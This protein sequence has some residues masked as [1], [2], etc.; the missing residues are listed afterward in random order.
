[1][2]FPV[3]ETCLRRQVSK[4]IFSQSEATQE[5]GKEMEEQNP[6]GPGTGKTTR[7]STHPTHGQSGVE[8]GEGPVPD[9][10]D[11]LVAISD[12]HCQRF[13]QFRYHEASG[14]REVCSQL[15]GLCNQW[16]KP[17]KN[18]KKQIL[19]LVILEQFLTILPQEMQRWARG[20]GPETSSQAVALAEGFLLSQTEKRQAEQMWAPSM[21]EEATFPEAEGASLEEGQRVQ[22]QEGAQ[23]ALPCENGEMLLGH[24]LSR[25]VET[26]AAAPVQC[27]FSL[28]EVSVSFTEAEWALLDPGQRAL[29]REVMLENYGNVAFLAEN[30]Q[31][32]EEG[33]EFHPQLPDRVKNEGLEKKVKNRDR[34]KRNKEGRM[35]EK[36]DGRKYNVRFPKHR[37]MKPSKSIQ[38]RKHIWN[39]S[40][41][42]VHQ[43]TNTEEKPFECSECGKKFSES[44]GLQKHQRTHTGEKPFECAVCGKK[45]SQSG[46]LQKHRRTH[47]AEKPFEC[48]VCGK[49]FSQSGNLQLHQRT[50]TG[51]KPFECSECG[52]RFSQS[53]TL[54]LHQRIHTGEK[55]FECSECGKKFSQSGHLQQHQRIH[56]AEKPFECSECGKRFSNSGTLLR[57]Q[58]SHTGEKPF[59]CLE[60]GKKFNQSNDLLQH[61]TTHAGEKPFECSECGKKFSHRR[62]LQQHL[63]IHRGDKPFECSECGKRF[64]R[65]ANLQLHQRTHTG[66]KPFECTLCG[67]KF[68]QSCHLKLHQG[69]HTGEKPFECSECGKG[70]RLSGHLQKHLTSHTGEKPYECSQCGKRFSQSG[71]LQKHQRTHAGENLLNAQVWKEVQVEWQFSTASNKPHRGEA[72]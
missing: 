55:P 2:P 15:H 41:L 65:S 30:D 27:P 43:K 29:Y 68:S 50:H 62:S 39:K 5:N 49:K 23:D 60:C 11:E 28:D 32:N 61:Q 67:K 26:A 9:I 16:L 8:F 58:R 18:S 57:H 48:A 31:R 47:T 35:V 42:L 46:S 13:R 3:G 10:H 38:C 22:A 19:D 25:G 64:S 45:F 44:C 70:F 53:G 33:E 17:E 7:K 4:D 69:T 24:W 12:V 6:E 51:E 71:H 34:P 37:I 56:T 14:P 40:Q 54:Q 63:R 52:K 20:C 1:M 36:R 66:E 59:E 72:L 21:K